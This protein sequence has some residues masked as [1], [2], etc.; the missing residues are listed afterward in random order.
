MKVT[1]NVNITLSVHTKN[2]KDLVKES[3]VADLNYAEDKFSKS[4]SDKCFHN[5][6]ILIYHFFT[7]NTGP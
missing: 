3:K 5:F 4:K 6:F 7:Y 2:L 1:R